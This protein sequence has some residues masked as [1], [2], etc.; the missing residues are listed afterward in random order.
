[1]D[2]QE[3]F[4]GKL[5]GHSFNTSYCWPQTFKLHNQTVTDK[6][7]FEIAGQ[8]W[9]PTKSVIDQFLYICFL[10]ANFIF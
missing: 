1:M 8:H 5:K 4:Y 7:F 2:G 3:R 6:F 10:A 9:F